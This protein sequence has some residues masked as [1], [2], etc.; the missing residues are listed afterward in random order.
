MTTPQA[1][2][3]IATLA[4][5]SRGPSAVSGQQ[6]SEGQ[7]ARVGDEHGPRGAEPLSHGPG[8]DRT[9]DAADA[10]AGHDETRRG[11]G[12]PDGADQEDND[13]GIDHR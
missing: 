13:E 12:Q 4:N 7:A 5:A 6:E 9:E 3:T 1:T 8:G 2:H 11:R 10:E